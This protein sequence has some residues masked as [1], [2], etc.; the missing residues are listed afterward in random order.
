MESS[1]IQWKPI[2]QPVNNW[3]KIALLDFAA[4]ADSRALLGIACQPR[5]ASQAELSRDGAGT[6]DRMTA[7]GEDRESLREVK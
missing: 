7:S 4:H 3:I 5:A 6:G 1:P 2:Q